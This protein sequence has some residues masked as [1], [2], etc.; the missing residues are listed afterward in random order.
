MNIADHD[1]RQPVE[2]I[3]RE[4]DRAGDARRRELGEE[5]RDQDADRQRDGGAQAQMIALPTIPFAMPPTGVLKPKASLGFL[6]RNEKLITLAPRWTIASM[7]EQQ[8]RDGEECREG[9]SRSASGGR[10]P[11]RRRRLP[12]GV[13]GRA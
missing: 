9:R 5:D 3:E 6:V 10:S 8:N 12:V 2:Q 13:S 4:A 11:A 1:R 7:N